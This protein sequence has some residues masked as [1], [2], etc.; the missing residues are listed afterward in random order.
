MAEREQ[1]LDGGPLPPRPGE[2]G[3]EA[4]AV[5]VRPEPRDDPERDARDQAP[6]AE[7]L[8]AVDV[9]EMHLHHRPADGRQRVP[10]GDAGVG[11]RGGVDQ[12]PMGPVGTLLDPIDERPLVVGLE[13]GEF[14]RGARESGGLGGQAAVD[15]LERGAPVDLRLAAAEEVQVRAVE[16]EDADR[17]RHRPSSP[18]TGGRRAGGRPQ[19]SRR[20]ASRWRRRR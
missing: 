3:V 13:A 10:Q 8:A 6:V 2:E 1:C 15:L 12:D 17:L 14:H 7:G 4:E 20:S 16:H 5:A 18:A 19:S 11:E 9:G